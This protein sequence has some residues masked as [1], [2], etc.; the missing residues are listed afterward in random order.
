MWLA[1]FVWLL[2]CCA[3]AS[4]AARPTCNAFVVG[5]RPALAAACIPKNT[6]DPFDPLTTLTLCLLAVRNAPPT[7]TSTANLHQCTSSANLFMLPIIQSF[8]FPS[9]RFSFAPFFL[10]SQLGLLAA[11]TIAQCNDT[12][13]PP[14]CVPANY[15]GRT[16]R[17]CRLLEALEA[18]EGAG[19]A[20]LPLSAGVPRDT[21]AAR[22]DVIRRPLWRARPFTDT[23]VLR[24][25]VSLWRSA[26]SPSP[27]LQLQTTQRHVHASRTCRPGSDG[28]SESGLRTM[29]ARLG[30]STDE[31]GRGSGPQLL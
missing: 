27:L 28:T 1:T 8:R 22:A 29:I 24:L 2:L 25:P 23:L 9:P 13:P 17:R 31:R 7:F 21:T 26:S 30:T 20:L 15:A 11:C 14:G 6:P 12:R 18:A 4:P 5:A 19:Q 10:P 3:A 16:P